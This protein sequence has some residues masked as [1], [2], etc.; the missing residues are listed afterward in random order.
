M[1]S[2]VNFYLKCI[3]NEQNLGLRGMRVSVSPP[4]RRSLT[5]TITSFIEGADS[6]LR[7]LPYSNPVFI[8]SSDKSIKQP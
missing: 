5:E 1:K 4:L 8:E 2:L 6:T 3:P 7:T